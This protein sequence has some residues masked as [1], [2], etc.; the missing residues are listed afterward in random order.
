MANRRAQLCDGL[1]PAFSRCPAVSGSATSIDLS[2]GAC[3]RALDDKLEL[4]GVRGALHAGVVSLVTLATAFGGVLGKTTPAY[5]A[6][7]A[8][9]HAVAGEVVQRSGEIQLAEALFVPAATTSDDCQLSREE[10]CELR[11][12]TDQAKNYAL[13]NPGVGIL[14]HVG[15]DDFPNQHFQNAEQFGQAFVNAF[16]AQGVQSQVFY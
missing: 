6:D 2:A 5:A 9:P 3:R 13:N 8:T 1:R 7:D 10:L 12:A 4:L 16:A 14:I 15:T 11:E